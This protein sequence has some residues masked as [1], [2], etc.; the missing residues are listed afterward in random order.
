MAERKQLA[1]ARR[2][3]HRLETENEILRRATAWAGSSPVQYIFM[4]TVDRRLYL[5]RPGGIARSRYADRALPVPR[6]QAHCALAPRPRTRLG[7]V[8]LMS[9][10][11]TGRAAWTGSVPRGNPSA[12]VIQRLANP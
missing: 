9:V 3:I 1:E 7:R 6:S 11:S 5:R 10:R 8:S 2:E 4:G 12:P